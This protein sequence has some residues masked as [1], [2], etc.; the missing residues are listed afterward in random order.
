M[1]EVV[2]VA[3]AK[4]KE[5]RAEEARALMSEVAAESRKE[6]GCIA[7]DLHVDKNDADRIVVLERWESQDAL[8]HHFTLPHTAKVTESMD[9]LDELPQIYFCEA[10]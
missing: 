7:Y 10:L 6:E 9:M 2:V 8:D 4:S 5:G 3:I 1:S